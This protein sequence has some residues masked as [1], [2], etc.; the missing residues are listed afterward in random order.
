MSFEAVN[1]WQILYTGLPAGDITAYTTIHATLSSMS[2]N[3]DNIRLRIKDTSDKYADVK[4]SSGENNINLADLKTTYPNCNFESINDITIWS[5]TSAKDEETVSSENPASVVITDCYIE[6]PFAFAFDG[7]GKAV[8]DV[9]DLKV[10]GCY[11]LN[12]ETGVLVNAYDS[13]NNKDGTVEINF[14]SAV[15]MSSVYGFKVNYTGDMVLGGIYINSG[16][17]F[18]NNPQGRTDIA[19]SMISYSSVTKW[20]WDRKESTGTMNITSVEFYQN[21]ISAFGGSERDIRSA[22][23]YQKD[24]DNYVVA[25]S[26]TP[27]YRVN[28][29]TNVAYFGVDWEGEKLNYYTDLTGFEKLRVYQETSS[30]APRPFFE[31][32]TGDGHENFSSSCVWNSEAGYYE[33]DLA[34]VQTAVGN[35]HLTTLRPNGTGTVTRIVLTVSNSNYDYVL[36]GSGAFSSSA[37]A[38]LG[39]VNATSID[40]T[41]ITAATELTTANPNCLII[42]NEGMVTNTK[43]VIVGATCANLELTDGKP[44][45]APADFTATNATYN[46]TIQSAAGA[47]TLCLPF[48]ATIPEGVNAYTLAYTSGDKATA[49]PVTGT[50]SANT[51]VLLNGSGVCTFTGS[52]AVS[53]SANNV[54]GALTGVFE[55]GTVPANSY[56]LQKQGE[57]VGFYKVTTD[58]IKIKPFRA[59]LTAQSNSSRISIVYEDEAAGIVGVAEQRTESEAVYD[60]QGRRVAQPTKGLYIVNGKLVIK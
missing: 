16:F 30:P 59:Y 44:F 52:G 34:S 11:T 26:Y 47:G 54:S 13:E 42:A 50:I 56:V 22:T 57:N 49:T 40:A 18:G 4:L 27:S 24:G 37:T 55:T 21:T 33:L 29:S 12:P 38:A 41:G 48:A 53:A 23:S 6:K 1:G 60:L 25:T 2:D 51:P 46:T 58:D 43:N 14:P 15:D 9:T 35:L 32:S 7:T 3:I 10:T 28:E 45:K 19:S 17:K 39:D 36:S 20:H 31:K 5:P 8:V